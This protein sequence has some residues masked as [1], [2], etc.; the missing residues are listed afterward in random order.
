MNRIL[1]IACLALFPISAL[2]QPPVKEKVL[3][4]FEDAADLKA[5]SNLV[6][7]AGKDKE[8]TVR[9]ELSS[10]H[11]TSGKHSLKLTFNGGNWP[12]IATTQVTDDWLN[13][14]TFEADVYAER[15]CLVGFTLM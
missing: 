13:Y 3:Y 6:L 9:I 11:A 4:D 15:P 8:P 7:P 14:P 10:D 5:W 1:L 2:A 12:T